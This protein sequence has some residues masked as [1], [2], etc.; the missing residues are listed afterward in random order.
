MRNTSPRRKIVLLLLAALLIAP[1]ASAAPRHG[2][3][4]PASFSAEFMIPDFLSRA[5]N[6]LAGV[7][8]KVGCNIDPDG[9]CGPVPAAPVQLPTKEGC[10]IDPFGRCLSGSSPILSPVSSAD[11]GCQIDPF[12][13]CGS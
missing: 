2:S 10:Q 12:G 11:T 13:R 4:H 5:W 8:T 7:W 9:R 3:T 6:L 1:W